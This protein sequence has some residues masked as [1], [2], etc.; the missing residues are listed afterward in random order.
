MMESV[1]GAAD[2]SASGAAI[3]GARVGGKTGTAENGFDENGDP[4]PYTLWFTGYAYMGDKQG[5]CLLYTSRCV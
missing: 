3:E 2:G 4:L 5:R 1:V